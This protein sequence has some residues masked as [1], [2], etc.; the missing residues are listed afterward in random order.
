M[1]GVRWTSQHQVRLDVFR[2][3]SLYNVRR[4]H[5]TL[6]YLSPVQFEQQ[7]TAPRRVTLAA[8]NAGV[9]VPGEGSRGG[10]AGA[11]DRDATD[12]GRRV[13]PTAPPNG[14]PP[15]SRCNGAW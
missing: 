11:R 7:I 14:D 13:P 5:S 12:S 2:Q 4:C 9:H 15:S 3:I 8:R 10:T 6:G 1:H